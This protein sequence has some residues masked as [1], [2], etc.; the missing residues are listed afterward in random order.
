MD[1][2]YII[3]EAKPHE[4][5]AIGTLMVSKYSQLEDFPNPQEQPDYYKLLANIGSLIDNPKVKLVA[6]IYTNGDI[7]GAVV[8]F[9]DMTFY[10]S[11]D[12]AP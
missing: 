7:G 9:G 2:G 3:R 11:G 10:G 12:I 8:Y 5:S 4:F 6:A 1:T